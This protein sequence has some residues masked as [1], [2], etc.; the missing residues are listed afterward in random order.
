MHDRNI[1]RSAKPSDYPELILSDSQLRQLALIVDRYFGSFESRLEQK[2][3]SPNP[4]LV[5]MCHLYL[6]GMNVK[7]AAILLNRD[8]SSIVRY[9]KKMKKVFNTQDNMGFF[10]RKTIVNK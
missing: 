7:Q 4:I 8:Y 3:L 6:I 5:G 1:K 2:G 10:F 9:E